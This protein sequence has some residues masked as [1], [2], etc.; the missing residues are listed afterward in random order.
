MT[1]KTL[2]GMNMAELQQVVYDLDLPKFAAKQI[3]EWLY[4]KRISTIAEMTNISKSAREKLES[5]YEIGRWAPSKKAVS[6]DGTIKYLFPTAK[7]HF[8]ETVF[9]PSDDRGTL[10]VSSQVGCKMGCSFCMTGRQGFQAQLSAAEILNQIYSLPEFE[11]LTN[12]VF[13]GQGEPLDNVD[14]VLRVCEILTASYGLAWSPKRITV[15]TIGDLK[16]LKR[17]LDESQCNLA[18][19]LHFPTPQQRVEYMPAEKAWPIVNVIDLLKEYEF[20]NSDLQWH[21]G[22]KQRRLSFEYIVFS[23]LNDSHRHRDAIISLLKGL[24]CRVNLIPFHTIPDT[25]FKAAPEVRMKEIRDYLT[26]NGVFSTLRA[27]R[28]QDIMAACGLLT[29]A[30][31]GSRKPKNRIS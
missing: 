18:V 26:R 24:D 20:C 22:A 1:K 14:N 7:G 30:E 17:F 2:S 13:M 23:G 9:I 21:E 25:P 28:G 10:C 16:G 6:A 3:A 4:G 31:V 12:V 15:S 29:T 8:V 19:S 5:Q 11:R 27:S